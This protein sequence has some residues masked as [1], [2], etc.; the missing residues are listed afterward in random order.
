MEKGGSYIACCYDRGRYIYIIGG[1]QNIEALDRIDRF[2]ILTG[3][4]KCDFAKLKCARYHSFSF[5]KDGVI[6]IIGGTT[7]SSKGPCMGVDNIEAFNVE[8]RSSEIV[9]Q[10]RDEERE[11]VDGCCFDNRE[12]IYIITKTYI[13]RISIYE[14]KMDKT[15]VYP[16]FPK[17]GTGLSMVFGYND[18]FKIWLIT[19]LLQYCY[20]FDKGDDCGGIKWD[21]LRTGKG[22]WK[23]FNRKI[24]KTNSHGAV[25]ILS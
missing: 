24:T 17:G 11:I 13:Y 21:S 10:F 4:F 6:Y 16:I 25:G 1:I 18:G 22:E 3:M 14:W 9:Y 23:E 19:D 8:D 20:H 7:K 15:L 5:Y 12:Y 2:D